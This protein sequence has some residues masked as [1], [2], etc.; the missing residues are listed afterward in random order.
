MEFSNQTTT[1]E[2]Q[3]VAVINESHRVTLV[4]QPESKK[5]FVKKVMDIYNLPV[6]EQLFSTPIEGIPKIIDCSESGH[7]LTIIEEYISGTSLQEKISSKS[8]TQDDIRSYTADLC[9]ILAQLHSM[10]PAIIHR[11]IK[12]SNIIITPYNRVVLLDFNAA[13]H[14]SPHTDADTMLLG[15]QGYAAPEQYGFGASSPQTDIY[16][17]GVLLRE[18]LSSTSPNEPILDPVLDKII[19]KCTQL[20][21]SQRFQDVSEIK[22]I[23]SGHRPVKKESAK[24]YLLKL[25]P[26]GFRTR[27]PWKMILASVV[28]LF[29]AAL[30]FS[31]EI[32][33]VFGAALWLERTFVFFIIIGIIF[34]CFNYCGIQ[35]KLIPLCSKSRLVRA[36]GATVL[37]L[38]LVSFLMILMIFIESFM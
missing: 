29:L 11:D 35:Q 1:S 20:D 23:L 24:D 22:N 10:N 26:P 4:Q 36:I 3:T 27:R 2:Y 30:C 18:M 19:V 34:I 12:P 5:L 14:Y 33:N 6:Y 31:M 16:A 9:D 15:T 7:Q 21:P 32:Q 25:L 8:L 13:K 28:Y 37:S 38:A 17:L